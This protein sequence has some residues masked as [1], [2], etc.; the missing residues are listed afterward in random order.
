MIEL[1]HIHSDDIGDILVRV[2]KSFGFTFGKT[3][4]KDVK[5]F[6][7]LCDVITTKVQGDNSE[8]CTSQQAFYKVR[9]AISNTLH[10]DNSGIIP[11]TELNQLF[12]RESRGQKIAATESF[13]GF[14]MNI[15]RP[16]HWITGTLTFTLLASLVGLFFFWKIGLVVLIF[17]IA[18]LSL[19]SKLGN[20]L[21][22]HTVG[23]LAEKISRDHYLKSRRNSSTVN[24]NE[25][26]Q[27]VKELFSTGLDLEETVLT[28]DATFK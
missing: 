21:D 3:E 13:L 5:T 12:P 24:R 2:E 25:I 14:K 9:N 7:D 23:Q 8:D 26:A 18:G 15:L 22:L 28:R 6:G 1:K 19:A 4:L 10:V 20:E 17:S 27:K 11:D 16:R